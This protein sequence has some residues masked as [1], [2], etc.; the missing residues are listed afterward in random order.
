MKKRRKPRELIMYEYLLRRK[1]LS[2][3]EMRKY[4]TLKKGYEGELLFDRYIESL[5]GDFIFL[6]DLWL[7]YRNRAFQI[8]HILIINNTLYLYEIKNFP[9]EYYYENEKLYFETGKEVDDPLTQLKRNESLL[10]QLLYSLGYQ[11]PLQAVVVFVNPPECTLY[12]AP[13]TSKILLPT[14]LKQYFQHLQTSTAIDPIFHKLEEKFESIRLEKSPYEQLP[15]YNYNDIKKVSH[16][17][18]AITF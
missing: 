1:S 13:R 9:G 12:Q 3:E 5:P 16:V 10:R 6:H 2:H 11:I 4:R 7:S 14:Q 15:S 17:N 8:D 18:L